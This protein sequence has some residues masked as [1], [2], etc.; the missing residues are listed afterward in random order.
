[1]PSISISTFVTLLDKYP[2]F[3][4]VLYICIMYM[5]ARI[6]FLLLFVALLPYRGHHQI[7]SIRCIGLKI[8]HFRR[9]VP[10]L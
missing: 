1:M 7:L 2:L 3:V 5:L 9:G 10:G 4:D 6:L 8:M